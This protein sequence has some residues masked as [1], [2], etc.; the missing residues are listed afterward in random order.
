MDS[1][2][3][4][5]VPMGVVLVK[6]GKQSASACINTLF[7]GPDGPQM[8]ARHPPVLRESAEDN[9]I[10][11]VENWRIQG[12][13]ISSFLF[14]SLFLSLYLSFTHT[15]H[16]SLALTLSLSLSLSPPSPPLSLSPPSLPPSP[17]LSFLIFI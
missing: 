3:H 17:F 16:L 15:P 6:I 7:T 10:N 12:S 8:S 4:M 9:K 14:S 5:S 1:I 13:T 11:S 2:Q